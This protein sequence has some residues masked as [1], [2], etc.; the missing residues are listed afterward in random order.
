ML[1][2]VNNMACNYAIVCNKNTHGK[3]SMGSFML[4]KIQ[5]QGEMVVES[6]TVYYEIKDRV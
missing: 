1:N 2:V 4:S 3:S 6:V 5:F